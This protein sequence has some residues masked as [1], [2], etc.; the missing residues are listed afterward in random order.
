MAQSKPT[1][2]QIGIMCGSSLN[3]T[4][5]AKALLFLLGLMYIYKYL[6]ILTFY[7]T[8]MHITT[9]LNQEH[10]SSKAEIYTSIYTL[11]I[12]EIHLQVYTSLICNIFTHTYLYIYT[13][14]F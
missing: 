5:A 10:V 4:Q 2:Q 8:Y 9:Q 11:V 1:K 6:V 12:S 3:P 7:L 13:H 14:A